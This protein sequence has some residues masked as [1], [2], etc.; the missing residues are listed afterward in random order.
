MCN[1]ATCNHR[2]DNLDDDLGDL[3]ASAAPARPM[4]DEE[5]KAILAMGAQTHR[6]RFPK[7]APQ[8]PKVFVEQC[9]KCRGS[10]NIYSN[11]SGR[12]LG[13][14]FD[15]DGAGTREFK[16]SPEARADA[17]TKRAAK[18]AD[19][20]AEKA[21]RIAEATKLWIENH[22]DEFAWMTSATA[23]G[24]DFASNMLVAL[25][26]YGSLTENQLAA[27]RRCALK[28]AQRDADRKEREANAPKIDSAALAKIHASFAKARENLIQRPKMR[29]DTF[30][31]SLAVGGKNDGAI[32]VHHL[33]VRYEMDERRYMGTIAGEKFYGFRCS[34]E[35]EARIVAAASDPEAAAIAYGQRVG[36]CSICGQKLTNA[37]S[38]ERMIGPIC[39]SKFFG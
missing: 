31:F 35:E 24:F 7:R 12:Y 20:A 26:S 19:E 34:A 10:G 23:R 2:E 38:L 18:K 4:T 13:K 9:G 32:F 16:T 27:V 14:C 30:L 6:E 36:A 3:F 25:G 28:D 22:P 1:S 39:W 33:E 15:C 21:A 8:A 37:A 11:V 29:L 5:A 17:A